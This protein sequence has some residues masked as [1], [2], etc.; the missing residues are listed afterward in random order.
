M[1]RGTLAVGAMLVLTA[2]MPLTL[3][4]Q[5]I[6]LTP[7]ESSSETAI[8]AT[9]DR[10]ALPRVPGQAVQATNETTTAGDISNTGDT[11]GAAHEPAIKP[12]TG[13]T[14]QKPDVV[15]TAVKQDSSSTVSSSA[16]AAVTTSAEP[17]PAEHIPPAEP[18]LLS[19]TAKVKKDAAGKVIEA[20]F[21]T[22]DDQALKLNLD[23]K[24]LALA[25]VDLPTRM[26]IKGTI[27]RETDAAGRTNEVLTVTSY[28]D[29]VRPISMMGTVM[30][31]TDAAGKIVSIEFKTTSGSVYPVVLDAKSTALAATPP[32]TK[33]QVR[34]TVV[35]ETVADEKIV[36]K[37]TVLE[38]KEIKPASQPPMPVKL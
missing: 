34:C 31:A 38:F 18:V 15:S 37:M 29:H 3:T 6:H 30:S 12:D 25:A 33:V 11:P 9:A 19:G 36:N 4:A 17:A 22:S 5:E 14:E 21:E 8:E 13:A 32:D 16:D 7:T 23:E 35:T 20:I 24:G 27:S 2:G 10:D 1:T 28:R 26:D